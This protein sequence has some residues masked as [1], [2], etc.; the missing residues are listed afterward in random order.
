MCHI[1][2]NDANNALF[3]DNELFAGNQKYLVGDT[4][5]CM[6]LWA[7]GKVID[8]IHNMHSQHSGVPVNKE[9]VTVSTARIMWVKMRANNDD[10]VMHEI[11]VQISIDNPN[12]YYP[13]DTI[14]EKNV[15]LTVEYG[16]HR[17][18]YHS[19]D[20]VTA[21]INKLTS[22]TRELPS[23]GDT[24]WVATYADDRI[25]NILSRSD[26]KFKELHKDE[27]YPRSATV[28]ERIERLSYDDGD[29]DIENL[30]R[31]RFNGICDTVNYR[32]IPLNDS[33]FNFMFE[34]KE[35]VETFIDAE[36]PEPDIAHQFL[37][38]LDSLAV[39]VLG[40][41]YIWGTS[42]MDICKP[43]TWEGI[44]K[45]I[46]ERVS[47]NNKR[48][49]EWNH[50]ADTWRERTK[51]LEDAMTTIGIKTI[52]K[53]CTDNYIYRDDSPDWC[54]LAEAI[55]KKLSDLL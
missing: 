22:I 15:T 42:D 9:N 38:I 16:Q 53:A 34:T 45:T 30:V 12:G 21:A 37:K 49:D 7:D 10:K 4:L 20:E 33:I 44:S 28:V 48:A 32:A 6:T 46:V 27:V 24:F 47:D 8:P 19:I 5:F 39:Q 29:G 13:A 17:A 26:P 35:D 41:S 3:V 36:C 50:I 1:Y 55:I 11:N 40:E 14:I 23:V 31:I 54:G 51:M 18:L 43:S 25:P 2:M 52:S